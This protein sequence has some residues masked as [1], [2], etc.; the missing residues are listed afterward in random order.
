MAG[1]F[2]GSATS[3]TWSTSGTGSF[4]NNGSKTAIY[5]P[6]DA[7]ISSGSVTL[8]YTTNNP[9]TSCGAVNASVLLT[10]QKS[11]VI[12]SQPE[13]FGTCGT[14]AAHF[15]VVATGDDLKYQWYKGTLGS[16]AT[17]TNTGNINGAKTNTLNFVQATLADNGPY[18]V[19]VSGASQCQDVTSNQVTLNI[20][21]SISITTQPASQTVCEGTD[22]VFSVDADANGDPLSYQWRKNGSDINNAISLSYTVPTATISDNGDYDVVITGPN[23]YTCKVATSGK[24]TLTVTP[25][26]EKPIFD[27]G[28]TSTRC[29]AAESVTYTATATGSTNI[30]YTLDATSLAAGNI[31]EA[32]TGKVTYVASWNGSST[33]TAT[34]TGCNGTFSADHTVTVNPLP[35][36]TVDANATAVCY[37]SNAQTTTLAYTATSNSPTTYSISWNSSPLNSFA[38]VT[39]A[40]LS[41][42]SITIDVPA[43]TAPGSYSG[44]ISAKN[45]NGCQSSPGKTFTVTVNPLPT[46]TVDATAT[47]VCYSSNAQTTSLGYS[48]ATDSPT[49]YSISWNSSPTNSFV[50]V[51]DA[52]LSGNSITI[53]VPA[54]TAPGSYSGTISVKNV[55]GCQSSP[56]KTFTVTVNPLPTITVDATATAVCYSSNAQTTSLGYSGATNSPT[57]YSISWNSSPTN[58][59]VAVNDAS[60]SGNSITIDVPAGTAPGSYSGTISVKNVN[61]CQSS[62]GKTFTVT[63]NPLPTI[64]VDATATA[65]CYSSNAQTTSLGYSGATNSPTT[66]SISWNSSPTNSFVAV[67]D[68]SLSGNSITIDVPAGTAPGSYSGTI[69]V[70]NANG[71][72][73]SEGQPFSITVNP[74]PTITVDEN[75]TA[76]CF[77]SNA[78]TSLLGYSGTTNSPT[79]YSINWSSS[80]SSNFASVNDASLSGNSITINVPAGTVAGT[81]QGTI[82]VKNANGCGSSEGQPFSITV[83]PL[84]TATISRSTD[85]A[86]IGSPTAPTVTFTGANGTAPYTFTYSIN[87]VRQPSVVSSG[88]SKTITVPINTAGSFVYSLISVH[89]N[90]STAC[91]QAQ[92]SSVTITVSPVSVGGTLS[93]NILTGCPNANNGTF[94][95]SDNI[96]KVIRW[97]YSTDQGVNWNQ[98]LSETNSTLTYKDIPASRLYRAVIQSG[99]CSIAYSS[100]AM[101]SII[102]ANNPKVLDPDPNPICLGQSTLLTSLTGY[103]PNGISASDGQFNNGNSDARTWNVYLNNNQTPVQPGL[104]ANG[105]NK[106]EGHWRETNGPNPFSGQIYDVTDNSKFA[107][108]NGDYNS[109]LESPVFDLTGVTTTNLT[110]SQA[111]NFTSAGIGE[112]Q[113]S[114][115]GGKSYSSLLTMP[116]GTYGTPGTDVHNRPELL[117]TTF[118][119]NLSK[120]AGYTRLRIRFHFSGGSGNSWALDNLSTPG[121]ALPISYSW[122]GPS[123]ILT[124]TTLDTLRVRPTLAGDIPYVIT[125]MVGGCVGGTATVY[126][127]VH[128]TARV[129]QQP[130]NRTV[131]PEDGTSFNIAVD[132]SAD[133]SSY[134]YNWQVSTDNGAT[135]SNVSG[136][137]YSGQNTNT[138]N[139]NNVTSGNTKS[140]YLYRTS[141]SVDPTCPV[142]TNPALLTVKNI[143][144]GK[145]DTSWNTVSN[146]SDGQIPTLLCDS[147]IIL[148]VN[149]E[150]TL[151]TGAEGYVNHLVIRTGAT[152][153]VINNTLHIAAGIWDDNG[154]LNA[155]A[156]KIDLNGDD[157]YVRP[158]H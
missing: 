54:G 154:A 35:T 80:P 134:G 142:S 137:D 153:K 13:N 10:I 144:F 6:S 56:G 79:T 100:Y 7:D 90:S 120:Y 128:D 109:W 115:D 99:N 157:D 26:V 118:S 93:P 59:F 58:S 4:D 24:A 48:G 101:A 50:A 38:V 20:D 149:N 68:A 57:T 30:N 111:Y 66:Y 44:T 127:N 84:P 123:T 138:L 131:C 19:I 125:S 71:C 12:N 27:I 103:P 98:L 87:G 63:V 148:K 76:V 77:S 102:P 145:T 22:A 65:V 1:D 81:Y 107:I 96:G 72:G 108:A 51:N 152:V 15:G 45:A 70:K 112:I 126:V 8:T 158:G 156:G 18:Y 11:V 151:S 16:G 36:I 33:I 55:N 9:G 119:I 43:G 83:N 5:T 34:V 32:T 135:W 28:A 40:S 129:T 113:I 95:L 75:A 133:A 53:D 41:G 91:A 17:I 3:A 73:S 64:T 94:T 85:E 122:S 110:F 31:I 23:G 104:D 147:V 42:N 37:S 146:W 143:W 130:A 62:P 78:Q 69:S 124:P 67:N 116:A 141:V 29:Q 97:E 105:D 21:Q 14:N 121:G 39:D 150:P 132:G 155:T 60:L 82:T 52:S 25:H 89:D 140:G 74:L 139:V 46:I 106:G 86:C 88:N 2:G 49:T 61:G 92:T 117:L 114:T 47:A 136:L